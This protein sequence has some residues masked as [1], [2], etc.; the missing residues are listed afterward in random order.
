M[1]YLISL[2]LSDEKDVSVKGFEIVKKASEVYLENYTS[3]MQIS[4]DDLER[5]YGRKIQLVE[6]DFVEKKIENLFE[7]ARKQNIA[8]LVQGDVHSATTHID[9][10]LRAKKNNVPVEV[11]LGASIITAVGVTGLS[12]YNFGKVV[13]IPFDNKQ[14][15]S[16]YEN[17]LINKKNGLHTLFLLDLY[18]KNSRYLTVKEGLD[19]L[20]DNGLSEDTLVVGCA[21]M[22][23]NDQTIKAGK[24]INVIDF[25]FGKP[26]YCIIVPGKL[27]FVEEEALG[28]WR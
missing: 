2:G 17:F 4:K 20:K 25:D 15:K 3:K 11:I 26:P 22:G 9:L 28:L 12:L 23:S 19:Y 6:R 18:P 10:F 14:I 5:F 1:L 8:F 13:S 24:L 27:H 7:K 21:R 16:P